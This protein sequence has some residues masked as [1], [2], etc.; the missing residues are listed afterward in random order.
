MARSKAPRKRAGA[1]SGKEK[2]AAGQLKEYRRKRDF[3]RTR[4]PAGGA[5][6]ARKKTSARKGL[7]FV[8]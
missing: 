2:A 4:E 1:T 7:R 5:G 3:S 8:I 6:P